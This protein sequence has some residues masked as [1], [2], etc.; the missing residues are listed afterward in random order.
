MLSNLVVFKVHSH[1]DGCHCNG[2]LFT[3]TIF[4]KL[5][6]L[7][8]TPVDNHVLPPFWFKLGNHALD[9]PRHEEQRLCTQHEMSSRGA[10]KVIRAFRFN[11]A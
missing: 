9:S 5:F 8:L 3:I 4:L 11:Q 6:W 10:L 1:F 7:N 2:F